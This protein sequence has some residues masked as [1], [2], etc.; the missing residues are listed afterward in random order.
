MSDF[1]SEAFG[2]FVLNLMIFHNQA[3]FGSVFLIWTL[4]FSISGDMFLNFDDWIISSPLIL[5]SPS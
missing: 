3:T 5:F 4:E 2:F 1:L